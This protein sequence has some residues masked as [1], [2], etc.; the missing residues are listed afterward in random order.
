MFA[1]DNG[2]K[3]PVSGTLFSNH[4]FNF[5]AAFIPEMQ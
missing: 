4:P 3:D 2:F 1:G 5:P